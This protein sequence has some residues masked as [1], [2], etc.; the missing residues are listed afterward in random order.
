M[1]AIDEPIR[2]QM[3]RMINH[4][5]LIRFQSD[6]LSSGSRKTGQLIRALTDHLCFAIVTHDSPHLVGNA[7]KL[8]NLAPPLR[9]IR[10]A[11]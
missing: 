7:L 8:L 1:V 9:K 4:V 10:L 3:P 11:H 6:F 5:G 2:K